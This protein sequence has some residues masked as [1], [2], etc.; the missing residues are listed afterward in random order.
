[1]RQGLPQRRA[2]NRA[3]GGGRLRRSLYYSLAWG[4]AQ[5]Q[6]YRPGR[7]WPLAGLRTRSK[8]ARP[9]S[10]MAERGGPRVSGGF[11]GHSGACG[12][13]C[14]HGS[15]AAAGMRASC[16]PQERCWG[17]AAGHG[18]RG[19]VRDATGRMDRLYPDWQTTSCLAGTLGLGLPTV[20]S[21]LAQVFAA[22]LVTGSRSATPLV[23]GHREGASQDGARAVPEPGGEHSFA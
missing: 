16:P 11:G 10:G 8:G 6:R 20:Q 23:R 18:P 15:N 12:R 21:V 19:R 13:H 17:R 22:A 1:M 2:G 3:S 7:R 9:D 5:S 14:W 4:S